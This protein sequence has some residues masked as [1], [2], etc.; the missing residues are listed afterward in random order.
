MRL[1]EKVA[2]ITGAASGFGRASAVLFAKE[3]AR[4]V[5]A[6]I[7][8]D[9]GQETVSMVKDKGGDATF[10]H[11]DVSKAVEIQNL[12]DK[13]VN[14]YNK[15][16]ILF[17]NAGIPQNVPVSIYKL[18]EA[19]WDKV[20]DTNVK[21]IYLSTKYAVPYMR[22]QGSGAIINTASA[23]AIAIRTHMAAYVSSKGAV[24]T[25]TKAL[26]LELARYKIRVNCLAPVAAETP[27]LP[28]FLPEGANLEEGRKGIISTIP[29]GRI[30]EPEDVAYSALFL[31]SDEA[32]MVSGV[33]L[34]VDGARGLH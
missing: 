33:T 18:E 24:I 4:V 6:D 25:L 34:S 8:D 14:T 31:A 19:E 20:Y 10:I 7:N 26:A 28:F 27:M 22:K 1:A 29:L 9:G 11:T 32:S 2:V 23:S 15:I 5:V 16:D 17:N 3:G 21:S 13:A 30:A 12:I